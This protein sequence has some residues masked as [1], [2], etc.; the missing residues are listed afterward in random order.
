MLKESVMNK[1]QC[2]K[3]SATGRLYVTVTYC[4]CQV[5]P[6]AAFQWAPSGRSRCRIDP[7]RQLYAWKPTDS[8]PM[9]HQ[10][11]SYILAL[12]KAIHPA[13]VATRD[14]KLHVSEFADK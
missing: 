7:R 3:V 12:V 13:L 5:P 11:S 2:P 9:V 8:R 10:A 4:D 14:L 6:T 1:E